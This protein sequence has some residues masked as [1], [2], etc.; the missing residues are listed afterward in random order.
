MMTNQM[1]GK[2]A[3]VTGAAAGIGRATALAFAQAGARVVVS[4]IVVT[5]GQETVQ[6]IQATGQEALFVRADVQQSAEVAALIAQ[7]IA[8]YGRLDYACN[9]AGIEGVPGST[10]DCTEENWDRVIAVNLKGIWLGMKYQIP[11]MLQRGKGAIVNMASF[12]GLVGYELMPAYVASKHGVIGLTKTAALEYVKAGIRINAVCPGIIATPMVERF[13]GGDAEARAQLA[14]LQPEGRL[15]TPEE[16]AAAVV[17][18]CTDSA[19]F[20]T[21]HAFSVDG[22]IVAR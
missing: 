3:L 13:T 12:L 14:A 11:A 17:W 22:G 10:V 2:V 18:L 4:D 9:N 16:I 19:S 7:T 1:T 6:M 21:G 20:V 15:G 5:G 8:T